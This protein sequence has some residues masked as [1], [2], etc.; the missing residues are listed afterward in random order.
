MRNVRKGSRRA[1][2][3]AIEFPLLYLG[4]VLPLSFGIIFASEMWWV[5]HSMVEF[6]REGARYA[7][8]H[9]WQSDAANV[10]GYMQAHVPL[11]ID[12]DQ[13][14]SGPA[15]LNVQY[16]QRDPASGVLNAFSCDGDCS[17]TC[18]PDVVTVSIS[19]Y[20]F[21]HFVSFLR[22]PPV[23][24]PEFLTSLPM[25]SNGCDPEQAVCNP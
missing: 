8:T 13:F 22:L 23:I 4:I 14:R 18:V 16:F 2:Q 12:M 19:S 20:E 3:A 25:E 15:I 9:C 5:W 17:T 24:M 1:G 10:T 6:T 7:S 21:R 11:T